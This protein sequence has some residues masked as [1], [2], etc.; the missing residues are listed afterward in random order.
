MALGISSDLVDMNNNPINENL[1]NSEP[2]VVME[3]ESDEAV[4]VFYIAYASRI[5]FSVRIS[6]SR[7]SRNDKS[8]IMR[9][10]VCSKEGFRNKKQNY[11]TGKRKRS[12]A[13]VR[14]GCHAMIEVTQKYCGWWVVVKLIKEHNLS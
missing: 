14:E 1:E 8:I 5:G 7:R 2:F 6:K 10:F 3:F 4:K 9:R 13:T 11:N 12:R